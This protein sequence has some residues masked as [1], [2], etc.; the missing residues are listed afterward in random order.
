MDFAF[1]QTPNYA[2]FITIEVPGKHIPHFK[3]GKV[4][5]EIVIV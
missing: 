2:G 5:R 4:L 1:I 3:A